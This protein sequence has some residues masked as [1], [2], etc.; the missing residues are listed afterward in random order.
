MSEASGLAMHIMREAAVLVDADGMIK[1]VSPAFEALSG[2]PACDLIDR[3][4]SSLQMA[5]SQREP[6]AFWP[7]EA[8]STAA[9]DTVGHCRSYRR[10]DGGFFWG[11]AFDLPLLGEDGVLA[12]HYHIVRDVSDRVRRADGLMTLI[13]FLADQGVRRDHDMAVLLSLGCDVF[14]LDLGVLYRGDEDGDRVEAKAGSFDLLSTDGLLEGDDRLSCLMPPDGLIAD[15]RV[16]QSDLQAH[17][18]YQETGLEAW[19]TCSVK[20]DG[21]TYGTLFFAGR[22]PR[23][24]RFDDRE[25]QVLQ[26]IARWIALRKDADVAWALCDQSNQLLARSEEGYRHL[27]EKTPAMLHSIDAFGRLANVSDH[28][29]ET[30]GYERHEVIGRLSTDFLTDD[31]RRYATDVVL[32]AYR[33]SG[34]CDDIAY[35]FV[36]KNGDVRDVVLSAISQ[37]DENGDFSRSLAVLLDV[38]ERNEVEQALEEKTRALERS[39]ADLARFA[40]I[41]SHDLQEPLRR[42][43]TYCQILME[44]FGVELSHEAREVTG[45]IQSG[46]RRLRLM[47]NDLLNYVRLN[48]QFDLIYEPVDMSAILSHALDDLHEE[49]EA[50]GVS[51]LAT[52]LPLV[53][54]R[55]P[56]LKMVLHHLLS[57]AVKY[58]GERSPAI[59]VSVED[60]GEVWRFA[61]ADHG[62][63][64]EARFADRI[65]EIFQR[66]D[67]KDDG[68]GSGS[69]LAICRLVIQR[70]GGEIWLDRCYQDGARFLFTLPKTKSAIN[71]QPTIT[72]GS[73]VSKGAA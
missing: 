39:N 34:R 51:V 66:L 44:D 46:G 24:R 45:V 4:L 9:D 42:V 19:L 30:L 61:I 67:A 54:G 18:L 53:W 35:Q 57:N 64:V 49:I 68:E 55:G 58:G 48:E 2:F 50:K 10:R 52:P 43:I 23:G 16:G 13:A 26:F 36:A 40:Q 73:R 31:S 72:H 71:Q 59:D 6:S 5:E 15:E 28:W 29:L 33:V 3:S 22:Q 25:K 8:L 70:L 27:Y 20:G 69:G 63:G 7:N 56:L 11:E 32:P 65:F 12:G 60:L 37:C 38:T 62:V 41:A 17:P 47:I 14:D 1:R 21:R